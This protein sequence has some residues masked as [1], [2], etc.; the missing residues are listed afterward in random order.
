MVKD[1]QINKHAH[2]CAKLSLAG[3]AATGFHCKE[4]K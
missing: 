2:V 3:S 4:V 1:H